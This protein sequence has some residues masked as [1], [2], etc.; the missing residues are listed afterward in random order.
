MKMLLIKLISK[1]LKL[2]LQKIL[3][4]KK[5]II[6]MIIILIVYLDI[7]KYIILLLLSKNTLSQGNIGKIKLLPSSILKSEADSNLTDILNSTRILDL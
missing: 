2:I 4:I 1:K 6:L 5:I 7:K 3:N